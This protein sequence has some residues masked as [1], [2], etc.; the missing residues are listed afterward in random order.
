MSLQHPNTEM[1]NDAAAVWAEKSGDNYRACVVEMRQFSG[2]H[3]GL[4]VVST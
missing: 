2:L 4:S 3:S 1:Y